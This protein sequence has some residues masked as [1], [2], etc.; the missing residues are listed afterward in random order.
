ML[1]SVV[2]GDS[3]IGFVLCLLPRSTTVWWRVKFLVVQL[4]PSIPPRCHA[5]DGGVNIRGCGFVALTSRA[6]VQAAF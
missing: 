5:P 2:M 4:I 6:L 1:L 3:V